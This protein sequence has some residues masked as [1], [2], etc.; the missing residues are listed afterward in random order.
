[1][2]E[3]TPVV[4]FIESPTSIRVDQNGC[5]VLSKEDKDQLNRIEATLKKF[6]DEGVPLR[7]ARWVGG[8][9]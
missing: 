9:K 5:V 6:E 4:R 8:P 7:A 1:M 3:D 2:N